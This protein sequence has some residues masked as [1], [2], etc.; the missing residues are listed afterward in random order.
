[1][2][3]KNSWKENILKQGYQKS[4]KNVTPFL[5]SNSVSLNCCEKQKRPE[6]SFYSPF[7]LP[8]TSR[9]F[10]SLVIQHLASFDA[11]VGGIF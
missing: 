4:S 10:L 2:Y 5:C 7:R 6:T 9:S 11:S 8:D 3:L 1:M